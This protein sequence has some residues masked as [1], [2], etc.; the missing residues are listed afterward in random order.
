MN[1]HEQPEQEAINKQYKLPST[2]YKK[3]NKYKIQSYLFEIY[4]YISML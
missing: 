4:I 3:K 1:S 2:F